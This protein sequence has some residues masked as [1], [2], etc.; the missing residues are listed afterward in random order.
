MPT[1]VFKYEMDPW[2]KKIRKRKRLQNFAQVD[3][4]QNQIKSRNILYNL[5]KDT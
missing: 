1:L 5:N 2:S 3:K 4:F